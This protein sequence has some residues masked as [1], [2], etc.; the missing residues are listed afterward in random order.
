MILKHYLYLSDSKTILILLQTARFV[1]THFRIRMVNHSEELYKTFLK[2]H[3]DLTETPV[4]DSEIIHNLECC[5]CLLYNITPGIGKEIMRDTR[6]RSIIKT[7]LPLTCLGDVR[8]F[9]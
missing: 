1:L 7:N 5:I 3:L 8:Y 4:F 6:V 9:D 2:L